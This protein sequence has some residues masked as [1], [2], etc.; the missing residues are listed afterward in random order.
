MSYETILRLARVNLI[1]PARMALTVFGIEYDS[2]YGIKH[3]S[4][5]GI[6]YDSLYGIKVLQSL[7]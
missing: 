2:L 4:L 1:L 5:Y 6:E 3:D 7:V